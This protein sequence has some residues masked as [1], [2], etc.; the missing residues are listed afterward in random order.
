MCYYKSD[1]RSKSGIRN[2]YQKLAQVEQVSWCKFLLVP[3]SWVCV[4]PIGDCSFH[5]WNKVLCL[6]HSES[7]RCITLAG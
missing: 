2:L 5:W 7:N 3:D 6:L 1:T 4:S